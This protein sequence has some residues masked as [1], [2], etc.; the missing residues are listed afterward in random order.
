M[1][2]RFR[3][4][5]LYKPPTE[6]YGVPNTQ[7]ENNRPQQSQSEVHT[8]TPPQ[9]LNRND[10]LSDILLNQV[11]DVVK[12]SKQPAPGSSMI[13]ELIPLGVELVRMFT[14]KRNDRDPLL[15][16]LRELRRAMI[17]R[18]SNIPPG[19][20]T[21]TIADVVAA[22][23]LLRGVGDSPEAKTADPDTA[24]FSLGER[25]L[26]V[27]AQRS[28]QAPTA[29]PQLPSGENPR[30][31]PLWA[32]LLR[33]HGNLI[34]GAARR[35]V[36]PTFAAEMLARFLPSEQ[37]GVLV[38]FLNRE[39]APVLL[40]QAIPELA[41]FRSWS[42]NVITSLKGMYAEEEGEHEGEEEHSA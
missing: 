11:L 14:E 13:A 23:K 18:P 4:M 17:E 19:P 24:L 40:L 34:L 16:E 29:A 21:N 20:A 2:K 33:R 41:D 15:E 3:L 36:D 42:E 6:I 12:A 39:D 8:G 28:G 30:P 25:I 7:Q 35:G 38:E 5:G 22:M 26:E 31:I 37:E 27:M 1:G 32:Q 10:L 9:S